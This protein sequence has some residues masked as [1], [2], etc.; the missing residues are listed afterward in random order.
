MG[1]MQLVS[2]SPEQV[3]DAVTD[4][5][6][7][8]DIFQNVAESVVT[9]D[10]RTLSSCVITAFLSQRQG[11]AVIAPLT[12]LKWLQDG[13]VK[14]NQECKWKFLIFQGTF[15]IALEVDEEPEKNVITF[16]LAK[17]AFMRDFEGSWELEKLP[18]GGCHVTH[19]LNITPTLAP[20]KAFENYTSKIFIRQVDGILGD[21][22]TALEA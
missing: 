13:V 2:C 8:P 19:V 10:V 17:S 7:A 12:C 11:N 9:R 14:V 16:K 15:G 18:G 20:P 21:L 22:R 1:K 6:R 3:Y 4:Y 5:A